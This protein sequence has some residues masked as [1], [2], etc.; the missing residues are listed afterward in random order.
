MQPPPTGPR[1]TPGAVT[2]VRVLLIVGGAVGVLLGLLMVLGL[3]FMPMAAEMPEAREAFER[4]GVDTGAITGHLALGAA[5]SLVY[6]VLALVLAFLIGRPSP[7]V[8]WAA[9]VFLALAALYA[10]GSMLMMGGVVLW[11]VA[12]LFNL[13]VLV[14]LLLRDSRAHHGVGS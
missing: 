3:A 12:L 13:A 8:F 10:L 2:A 11:M 5:Q 4:E 6:G 14:P 7:G 9:A 1:T